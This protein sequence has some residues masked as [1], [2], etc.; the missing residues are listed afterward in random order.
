MEPLTRHFFSAKLGRGTASVEPGSPD[1]GYVRLELETD[2]AT[3]LLF[4][5]A[6]RELAPLVPA[7]MDGAEVALRI[8]ISQ[9]QKTQPG[10]GEV[11]GRSKVEALD[12]A[13]P[14]WRGDLEETRWS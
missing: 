6:A 2:A 13:T 11:V 14:P 5:Y 8:A 10:V 4:T 3:P 12:T 1:A 7:H 9:A